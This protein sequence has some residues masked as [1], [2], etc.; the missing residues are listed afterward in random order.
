MVKSSYEKIAHAR[1]LIKIQL[2]YREIQQELKNRFGS[3]MS[4]STLRKIATEIDEIT[5]LRQKVGKLEGEL[6]FFKNL[7]FDL[8]NTL[9]KKASE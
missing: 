5:F 1:K 6:Q 7:Y 8:L 2:P 9:K 4:N 3:G